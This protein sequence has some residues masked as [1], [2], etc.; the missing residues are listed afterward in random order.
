MTP[1]AYRPRWRIP[2]TRDLGS[3]MRILLITRRLARSR[4]FGER[5]RKRV[6]QWFYFLPPSEVAA[7]HGRYFSVMAGRASGTAEAAAARASRPALCTRSLLPLAGG[8]DRL[9]RG[10]GLKSGKST[11]IRKLHGCRHVSLDG[12]EVQKAANLHTRRG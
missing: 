3:I 2:S 11:Y 6:G 7:G 8:A 9:A 5:E 10:L 4:D 12:S 1:P